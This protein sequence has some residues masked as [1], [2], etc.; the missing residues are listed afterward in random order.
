MKHHIYRYKANGFR[1]TP[2]EIQTDNIEA[3]RKLIR[4]QYNTSKVLLYYETDEP[5]DAK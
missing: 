2:C 5:F 3:T 4:E 1:A